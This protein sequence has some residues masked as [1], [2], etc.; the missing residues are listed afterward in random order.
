MEILERLL[1]LFQRMEKLQIDEREYVVMKVINF[2]NQD[3]KGLEQPNSVEEINKT[4]WYKTQ[5]WIEM[6]HKLK[7]QHEKVNYGTGATPPDQRFR[8]L[9]LC[10]PE[11]R[12]I[13]SRLQELT[14]GDGQIRL[15]L[16]VERS[17]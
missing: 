6:R 4:Y 1:I 10:L 8:A 11:I 14:L 13:A 2:L 3:V 16:R 15:V 17:A 12:A 5:A 7:V 9:M